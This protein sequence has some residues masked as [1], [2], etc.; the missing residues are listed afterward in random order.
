MKQPASDQA[1]PDR[2]LRGEVQ[3]W[4]ARH[5]RRLPE[6]ES[7]WAANSPERI[8]W[9][10]KVLEA[11]YAV[12]TWPAELFGLSRP[13]ESSAVIAQEFAAVGAPGAALDRYDIP[14]NTI[15][16]HGTDRLKADL[17][18]D[19]LTGRVRFCLLYSEPGA[20]SD[21][22]AV[23]TTAVL[24][25]DRWKV[26]G[27]KVWTSGAHTADYGLLLARTDWGATKHRGLSYFVVPM[28]QPGVE[29]R[30]L[31]Q[32]T[33]ESHFNEVFLTDV[34]VPAEYLLGAEGGG[35]GVLQTA[36]A[37]ERAGMGNNA[38]TS[39]H[40]SLADNL[41]ELA[42]GHGRLEDPVIRDSLAK[43]VALRELH[44]LNNTRAKLEA[45]RGGSSSVMSL[46]KLAVANL[47]HAEASVRSQI[48]GARALLAGD[49]NPESDDI[50]FL[51]LNAFYYSIGGGTDQIQ[52]NII[53]ERILGL[54]KE[55]EVD[56]DVP[57][58]EV[59]HG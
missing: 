5:W 16:Q 43:V 28:N 50:N 13:A 24:D 30:P 38:R 33:G 7:R 39:R 57:F 46:G 23:R 51:A 25:S 12:P 8:D 4:L 14:A 49:E 1:Q 11:G 31:V 19:A 34:Q 40:N 26:N 32:I 52:R 58:R 36:L 10:D 41:I 18:R 6:P 42:R 22:A 35:W 15:V 45:E 21:L 29:V 27:Q 55:P 59:R 48:V 37:F 53:G 17:L 3:A 20:G 2:Q 44:L 47:L 54:P 56:R 9:F